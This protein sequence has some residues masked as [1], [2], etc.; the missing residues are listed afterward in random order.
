MKIFIFCLLSGFLGLTSCNGDDIRKSQV[1]S[2]VLNALAE[3]YAGANNISWEQNNEGY[4]AVFKLNGKMNR[5]F[6]DNEGSVV[7]SIHSINFFELPEDFQVRLRGAYRKGD[8][9]EIEL[10]KISGEKFYQ[11][12][13]E[14]GLR[15][16]KRTFNAAGVELK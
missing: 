1:P 9:D 15:D 10:I 5:V 13:F 16:K 11:I 12:E 3:E 6:L 4:A 8:I 7:R 14:R 2:V